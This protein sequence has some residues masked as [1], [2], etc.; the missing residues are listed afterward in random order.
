MPTLIK[1]RKR[2]RQMTLPSPVSFWGG[3]KLWPMHPGRR[4]S[5]DRLGPVALAGLLGFFGVNEARAADPTSEPVTHQ[6]RGGLLFGIALGPVVGTARGYPNDARKIDRSEFFTSTG[7]SGGGAG[8]AW[9]GVAFTDW[10][11]FGLA[12]YGGLLVGGGD[13]TRFGALAFRVETFPG[14]ALGGAW[15]DFGA[16][17][18]AGVALATTTAKGGGDDLIASGGAS[19]FAFGLFYEGIRAWKVSMGPFAAVDVIWSPSA[20]R[21]LAWIGWRTSLYAKP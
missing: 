15:R 18:E 1:K 17:V 10:L 3:D 8:S 12:G 6:R 16:S 5:P 21:P 11:S 19:R 2:K 20:T 14:F 9:L 7:V 13:S 4:F